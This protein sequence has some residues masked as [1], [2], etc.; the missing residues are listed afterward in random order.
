MA[1][2]ANDGAAAVD[3]TEIVETAYYRITSTAR[4]RACGAGFGP[5]SET[6]V[7]GAL[8]TK[9]L[10]SEHANKISYTAA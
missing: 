1:K 3:V 4:F 2:K 9:L 6:E 8:L 7:T 10:A 5:Q